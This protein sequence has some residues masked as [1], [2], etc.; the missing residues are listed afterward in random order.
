VLIP[1]PGIATWSF[2]SFSSIACGSDQQGRADSY[3]SSNSVRLQNQQRGCPSART[4]RG[5]DSALCRGDLL[6][7]CVLY[8]PT[9]LG[10]EAAALCRQLIVFK[11][12]QPWLSPM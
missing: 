5:E 12:K 3:G 7:P 9:R 8:K 2:Y 4:M 6:L 11:R 10:L 1:P